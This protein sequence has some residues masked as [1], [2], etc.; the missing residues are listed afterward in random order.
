MP[1]QPEDY[2][3]TK[4]TGGNHPPRGGNDPF[5]YVKVKPEHAYLGHFRQSRFLRAGHNAVAAPLPGQRPVSPY[6][7]PV[8]LTPPL[9]RAGVP[10]SSGAAGGS[11]NVIPGAPAFRPAAPRGAAGVTR[12]MP[13]PAVYPRYAP[14]RA[15]R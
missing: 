3:S 10:A 1:Q 8:D 12:P 4:N 2:M 14:R 6:A 13:P 15:A 7:G 11:A 5:G 9:P